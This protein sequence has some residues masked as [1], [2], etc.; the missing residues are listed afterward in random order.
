[1]GGG[2][3]GG[4]GGMDL[5]LAWKQTRNYLM[6]I[7][8]N[9]NLWLRQIWETRVAADTGI[10][11]FALGRPTAPAPASACAPGLVLAG[12][13]VTG[14]ASGAGKGL[15]TSMLSSDDDELA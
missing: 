9:M 3:G 14:P 7:G 6:Q 8:N 10:S 2:G 12:A 11:G 4:E 13:A 5:P 15:G 1:M